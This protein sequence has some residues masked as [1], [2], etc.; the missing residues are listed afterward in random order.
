MRELNRY[1]LCTAALAGATQASAL[2]FQPRRSSSV[3]LA[4]CSSGRASRCSR[5]RDDPDA[6]RGLISA[7]VTSRLH[8][9]AA[10]LRYDLRDRLSEALRASGFTRRTGSHVIASSRSVH[11]ATR[12]AVPV[13]AC[14]R[15]GLAAVRAGAVE[16]RVRGLGLLLLLGLAL[17]AVQLAKVRVPAAISAPASP[18]AHAL[19]VEITYKRRIFEVLLDVC[20]ISGVP[21][22]GAPFRRPVPAGVSQPVRSRCPSPSPVRS[23]ACT[24]GRIQGCLALHLGGDL[25]CASVAC[26]PEAP[27]WSSRSCTVPL[28]QLLA[29]RLRDQRP[30]GCGAGR[31]ALSFR[32]LGGFSRPQP[33]GRPARAHLRRG[34]GGALLVRELRNNSTCRSIP[35]GFLDDDPNK[36]RRHVMGSGARRRPT[37]KASSRGTRR[38]WWSSARKV[39]LAA[40]ARLSWPSGVRD[41]PKQMQFRLTDVELAPLSLANVADWKG[42]AVRPVRPCFSAVPASGVSRRRPPSASAAHRPNSSSFGSRVTRQRSAVSRSIP[43]PGANRQPKRV[44]PGGRRSPC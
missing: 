13:C 33:V 10:D 16:C 39:Q 17:L 20:M 12:H 40:L 14:R 6:Q 42:P 27:S 26:S 36:Q 18:G 23:P 8:P 32:W 43:R 38:T 31:R 30:A 28:H 37:S 2:Q 5:S 22:V 9:A 11:R 44:Q 24:Q 15:R 35:I 29:Q 7:L 21:G 34:D 1:A 3:I 25:W 19:L 41:A 4:A